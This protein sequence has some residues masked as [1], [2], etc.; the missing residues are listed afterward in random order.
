MRQGDS[1]YALPAPSEND[2]RLVVS[3]DSPARAAFLPAEHDEQRPVAVGMST[4]FD[5]VSITRTAYIVRR[6]TR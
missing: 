4:W 1:D 5:D 6:P 3:E 2:Y